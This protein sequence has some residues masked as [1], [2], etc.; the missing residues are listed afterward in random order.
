[1]DDPAGQGKVRVV[2]IDDHAMVRQALAAVLA[3]SQGLEV[4][5][6]GEDVDAAVKFVRA[7][8]CD[9]M[10][11][12]YNLPG[13]GALS[14][15]EEVAR[16]KLPTR[17]LILTVHDSAH[18]AV[19]VL[20]AGAAGYMVKSDAVEEL[21]NAIRTVHSGAVY[22]SPKLSSD[23]LDRL[24]QPRRER[25]GLAALSDREFELLRLLARGDGLKEAAQTLSVSVSAAST[26]RSRILK[27]LNLSSTSELIRFAIENKLVE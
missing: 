2:L 24:R 26:Y 1:M 21:C 19:K 11:L 13:G 3:D 23:V 15:I 10:V 27:K 7:K 8:A 4:V 16:R 22:V 9:V 25:T 14:V 5:G 12:D 17:V 18:Y 6:Q 20:E